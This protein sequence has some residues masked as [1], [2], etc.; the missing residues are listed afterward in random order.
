M[1]IGLRPRHLPVVAGTLALLLSTACTSEPDAEP[2]AQAPPPLP[3]ELEGM[4]Q[5]ADLAPGWTR[6]GAQGSAVCSDGSDYDFFVRKA[7]PT[8]LLVYLQGGGACWFGENCSLERDPTYRH[9]IGDTDPA[10]A[11]GIFALD[12]PENPFAGHSMVYIPYCTGDVHIGDATQSYEVAATEESEAHQV[13]IEHRGRRNAMHVLTWTFHNFP[14]PESV[15]VTGSSAGS[16][17]SPYYAAKVAERYPEARVEQLGDG[18]GGYRRT[19]EVTVLPH[20]MWGTLDAIDDL[21]GIGGLTSEEF[22]Y[23]EIYIAAARAHP[24]ITFAEYDTA[25]DDVQVSFLQLAGAGEVQLSELLDANHADVEAAVD[26]FRYYVAGGTLHTIL[27]RPEFYTY[28]VDGVLV[29][30]W[31]AALA[32][33]E[34]VENVRCQRC[35]QAE[36]VEGSEGTATGGAR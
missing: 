13:T 14:N 33:G 2:E 11:D 26:N 36:V 20:E 30:D 21:A 32:A 6:V 22:D 18:A 8:K 7:D 4:P 5:L 34:P 29:R 15:F 9:E 19:T 16:I 24:E 1:K 12:H 17:P 35:D 28:Q 10:A 27:Q 25:G 31:V 3:A 23:E